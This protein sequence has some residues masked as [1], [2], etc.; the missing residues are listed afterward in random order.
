MCCTDL[1][2]KVLILRADSVLDEVQWRRI[3]KAI[4]SHE[5]LIALL[6]AL[7]LAKRFKQ[8]LSGIVHRDFES[9]L[10]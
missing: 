5:A 9:V 4:S 1:S 8:P 2:A 10:S 6:L 3:G 7:K